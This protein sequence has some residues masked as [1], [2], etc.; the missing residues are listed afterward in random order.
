MF[1]QYVVSGYTRLLRQQLVDGEHYVYPKSKAAY[2]YRALIEEI[3]R[4][5]N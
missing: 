1:I 3:I 2:D 5:E 4:E